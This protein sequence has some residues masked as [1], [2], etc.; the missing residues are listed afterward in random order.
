MG[1][2]ILTEAEGV[3][4]EFPNLRVLGWAGKTKRNHRLWKV[5]CRCGNT[6]EAEMHDL[7]IRK[8]V[9]CG[10]VR[11]AN[12][13]AFKA[14]STKHGAKS[15]DTPQSLERTW[16][17]WHDMVRRCDDQKCK[18]FKHYGGRGIQVCQRWRDFNSFLSDM[19]EA[20]PGYS[21]ERTDNNGNYEPDNCV[22]L[23][24]PEQANNRRSSIRISLRG[25]DMCLKQ[26]CRALRR[27]YVYTF[28]LIRY[29][30]VALHA[31]LGVPESEVKVLQM[32]ELSKEWATHVS[33]Q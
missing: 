30:G 33:S 21:I 10:C 12:L 3:A 4:K 18:A 5:L 13:V 27:P 29:R 31:A 25:S 22:W 20:P 2:K 26:A 15:A 24:R 16:G 19:G 9:S 32:P 14:S 17:I 7:Q 23:P 8:M 1:G 28:K 6:F 11:A